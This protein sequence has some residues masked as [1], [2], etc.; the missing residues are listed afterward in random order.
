MSSQELFSDA[1]LIG[2]LQS[3]SFSPKALAVL[4]IYALQLD[5]STVEK[6]VIQVGRMFDC[7][8]EINENERYKS[9]MD[10]QGRVSAIIN[11]EGAIET[12]RIT[13]LHHHATAT[14]RHEWSFLAFDG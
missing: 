5:V 11:F 2:L 13:E 10:P 9:R 8:K 3:H 7:F 6:I 4:K 14:A 12:A 1:F